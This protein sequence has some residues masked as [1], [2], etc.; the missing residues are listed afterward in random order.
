M[1]TTNWTPELVSDF[2]AK[3]DFKTLFTNKETNSFTPFLRKMKNLFTS[4]KEY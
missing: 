1:A 2:L 4:F 3:V